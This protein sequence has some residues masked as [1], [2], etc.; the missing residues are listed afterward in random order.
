MYKVNPNDTITINSH[1]I[2]FD[3]FVEAC[4]VLVSQSNEG[5]GC[6]ETELFFVFTGIAVIRK[7]YVKK[8]SQ[9]IS[10]KHLRDG[11]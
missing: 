5:C 2:P 11:G 1:T 7:E 6:Y 3:L 4:K 9:L 10:F 8:A